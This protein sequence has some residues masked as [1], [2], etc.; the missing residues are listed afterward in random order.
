M[1]TEPHPGG[2]A[3]TAASGLLLVRPAEGDLAELHAICSDPRV[4]T[5]FPTLRHTE[6]SQTAELIRRWQLSWQDHGLGQWIVRDP[7]S[8][9]MFGHGGC[10][11]R[12]EFCWNM[13]YRLAAEAHGRGLATEVARAGATAARAARPELPIIAYL[14]EHNRASARVAEKAGLMLRHRG[15]DAGNPDPDAVRLIYSDREL[16]AVQVVRA[17]E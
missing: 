4:W 16:S 10:A 13:G 5:H 8:G 14:L 1:S 6:E 17:L 7:A 9:Q 12:G 15:P 11:V 3:E 2:P